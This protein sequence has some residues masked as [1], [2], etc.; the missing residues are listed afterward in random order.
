MRH[1]VG[2]ITLQSP[3][4]DVKTSV[5][6]ECGARIG[7]LSAFGDELLIP[8]NTHDDPLTWGC[9]P[10]V[11]YAGRVR[12]AILECAGKQFPLRQNMPPHSIHGTVFDQTWRT[13][14]VTS[15][16]ALLEIELGDNWPFTGKVQHH[17]NVTNQS[18]ELQLT[19]FA[20]DP[21]PVQVG[22]HPWFVRPVNI[23]A[24]FNTLYV[25]DS[26]GIAHERRAYQQHDLTQESLD[27][28]FA[29]A[30][31][32]P[33]LNFENGPT[34]R[35]ETD[36]SHWVVYNEPSHAICVEPQSGPPNGLNSE[37]L[38]V[39]PNHPLTRYFRLTALGYR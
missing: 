20:V 29:D 34:V 17:V 32:A 10:M 37:P 8:G 23:E 31:T 36:C 5:Y 22:W 21:M 27:D 2:V 13:L 24:A 9:Y 15:Y 4:G 35:L 38:V 39:S 30:L 16:S 26:D 33:L 19:V 6:P 18:L 12:D 1:N 25:R 7:S 3:N 14:D 28:C 11:P